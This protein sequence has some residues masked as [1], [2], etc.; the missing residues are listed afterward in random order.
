MKLLIIVVQDADARRLRDAFTDKRVPFTKLASTGGFL[1]QGACTFLSGIA[2]DQVE[3]VKRIIEQNSRKRTAQVP[4]PAS[5][6]TAGVASTFLDQNASKVEVGGATVFS[7]NV[8][9]FIKL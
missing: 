1:R 2:D 8:E 7:L 4:T 5:V 3:K 6:E 9:E